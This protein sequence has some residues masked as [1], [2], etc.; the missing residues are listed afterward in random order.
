VISL[1]KKITVTVTVTEEKRKMLKEL[2]FY[3]DKSMNQVLN[4]I[5]DDVAPEMLKSLQLKRLK[6]LDQAGQSKKVEN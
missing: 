5:I 1:G 6:E 3:L 2:G 4:M